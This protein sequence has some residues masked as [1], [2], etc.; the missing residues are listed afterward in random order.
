MY[1]T[2]ALYILKLLHRNGDGMSLTEIYRH[3]YRNYSNRVTFET[4]RRHVLTLENIG[5]VKTEYKGRMRMVTLTESV[6]MSGVKWAYKFFTQFEKTYE[7]LWGANRE[8]RND[9]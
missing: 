4:V 3:V 2:M 5:A 9:S 7:N 8:K 6:K 1:I